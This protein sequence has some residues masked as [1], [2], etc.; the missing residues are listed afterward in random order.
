MPSIGKILSNCVM[1]EMR[2][3][4]NQLELLPHPAHTIEGKFIANGL[5]HHIRIRLKIKR[6]V[7]KVI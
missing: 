4:I 2:Q 7:I 6:E 3:T 1:L 5:Y